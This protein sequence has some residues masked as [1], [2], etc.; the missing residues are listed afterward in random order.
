MSFIDYEKMALIMDKRIV[1]SRRNIFES[2][3]TLLTDKPLSEITVTELCK[4]ALINRK[5]FYTQFSSVFDAFH[6][7][8][9][10]IIETFLDG[11]QKQG[12]LS[13]SHFQSDAFIR[14]LD[15]LRV[16]NKKEFDIIYPYLRGGDFRARF[17]VAVG[18]L[19]NRFLRDY[20][21]M[22][23]PRIYAAALVFGM[24]GI[25]TMYFDWLDLGM[26]LTIA[27][28]TDQANAIMSVPLND[29]VNII[30]DSNET[31]QG[32]QT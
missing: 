16:G 29:C 4:T 22:K 13:S 25:C 3:M 9:E 19:G 20:P 2:L 10:Q 7:L 18:Q 32:E 30:N 1:K 27:E 31:V 26:Q 24:C 12:I 14:Y 23:N 21:Q 11:L 15:D 5:T 6:C 8:E 28:L 17:G